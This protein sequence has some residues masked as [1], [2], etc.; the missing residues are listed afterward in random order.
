MTSLDVLDRVVAVL[1]ESGVEH[2]LVGAFSAIAYGLARA[3]K[4][5]DF[6]VACQPR[7]VS[8]IAAALGPDYALERQIQFETLTNSKRNVVTHLPSGFMIEFFYLSQDPHH[9]ERF[10]RRRRGMI[11]QLG[12][13]V[14]LPTPEDVVIQ[15]LRWRR[16][17]DIA[18][19][20]NVI[21]VCFD[22]LD[23]DYLRRWTDIHGTTELLDRLR[24][25]AA[26]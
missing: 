17:K 20:R 11:G 15:K 9:Q 24:G 13:G 18:D 21:A 1:D 5:A 2:M 26:G 14:W 7:D 22:T 8:R 6:V 4:D 16:E 12:R 3:T 25:E 23:W 19:S 10:Q